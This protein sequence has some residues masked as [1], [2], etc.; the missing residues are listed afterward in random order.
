[1][2]GTFERNTSTAEPAGEMS[3][4]ETLS[5]SL[6]S[7]GA[8]SDSATGS[9][10]GTGLMFGP[11][12]TSPWPSGAH[13][14]GH[15]G[16]ELRGQRHAGL[17]AERARIGDDAGQRRGR[18]HHRRAEIDLVAL[19]AAAPGEVAVER[20]QALGAG[21]R[22]VADARARAAR[23]LRHRRAAWPADRPAAPRGPSSR[24]SG[25]C[26]GTPRTRPTGCTCSLA[27]DAD[28]RGH[29]VPRAVRA[30]A[31]HHLVD[32]RPGDLARPAP[33]GRA[34]PAARRAGTIAL[35]SSSIW[36]S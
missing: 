7:T 14:A 33:R 10:S 25:G 27:D 19:H 6:S 21:G 31:D 22:D 17:G 3:S 29:V 30:R 4:V 26:P 28:D 34:S 20:A 35:R 9:P 8:S 16:R 23:R 12:T 2:A 1:M 11:R 24:G 13:E 15:R 32:R 18:R 36:S 5:P